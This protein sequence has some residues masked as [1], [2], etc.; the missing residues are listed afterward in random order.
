[1]TMAEGFYPRFNFDEPLFSWRKDDFPGQEKAAEG[2]QMASAK[3]PAGLEGFVIGLR[4]HHRLILNGDTRERM[5]SFPSGVI[6]A[7][8]RVHLQRL[9]TRI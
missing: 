7:D 2:L 1:M 3:T 5:L 4:T 6:H 9:L 8:L